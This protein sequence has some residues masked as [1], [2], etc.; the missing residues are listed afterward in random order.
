MHTTQQHRF[1]K[2]KEV[3]RVHT[4]DRMETSQEVKKKNVKL[5][6]LHSKETGQRK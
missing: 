4:A 6:L 5:Q 3:G 2:K 1:G